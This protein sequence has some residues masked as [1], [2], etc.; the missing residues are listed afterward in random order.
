MTETFK[1]IAACLFWFITFLR[2]YWVWVLPSSRGA[3]FVWVG[4][5]ALALSLSVN[6]YMIP[7]NIFEHLPHS[8]NLFHL[9]RSLLAFTGAFCFRI[10][11]VEHQ[12]YLKSTQLHMPRELGLW[13]LG[14][15]MIG[16][17]FSLIQQHGLSHRFIPD[18]LEQWPTMTYGV[19]F[20]LFTAWQGADLT[21][22]SWL[23]APAEPQVWRRWLQRAL[24]ISAALITGF[25][26]SEAWLLIMG[27]LRLENTA[28][29]LVRTAFDGGL[30][31]STLALSLVVVAMG[32][33]RLYR[34]FMIKLQLIRLTPLWRHVGAQDAVLLP[35]RPGL[36]AALAWDS[37]VHLYRVLIAIDDALERQET[38][39]DS[40]QRQLIESG[41]KA[42]RHGG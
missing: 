35:S 6:R 28:T 10:G 21:I 34:V 23:S 40:G 36:K 15:I 27:H 38:R 14:V 16:S 32:V 17:S 4:T 11:A 2:M 25:M 39:L 37:E 3:K 41:R 1:A 13:A 26:V 8:P 19:S 20:M 31:G 42:L 29:A 24:A 18:H 33:L 22:R 7:E 9:V 30:L 12:P 5:I